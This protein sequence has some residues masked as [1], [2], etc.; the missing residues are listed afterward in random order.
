MARP[1]IADKRL[2]VVH[3]LRTALG[4]VHAGTRSAWVLLVLAPVLLSLGLTLHA[5]PQ[6]NAQSMSREPIAHWPLDN[7]ANDAG[8]NYHGTLQPSGNGAPVFVQHSAGEGV[9]SHALRLDG[10]NDFVALGAHASN[11]PQ[12][13]S[14]RSITGWFSV[15]SSAIARSTF[16]AYGTRANGQLF[17][18]SADRTQATVGVTGHQ[19]GIT[20]LNLD[21]GW[22]HIA[23]IYPGN[24][25]SDAIKIY[26]DGVLQTSGTLAGTPRAINTGSSI[27]Q[28]GRNA[29]GDSYY[30]GD[31]DDVRVY[32]VELS[33]AEVMDLYSPSPLQAS[34]ELV[35]TDL[36]GA[37]ITLTLVGDEFAAT[38][39]NSHVTVSGLSGVSVTSVVRDSDTQLSVTLAHDGSDISMHTPLTFTVAAA[40]LVSGEDPVSA[41]LLVNAVFE[42]VTYTVSSPD[43]SLT[44]TVTAEGGNLSYVVS[45]DGDEL[46]AESAL[47]IRDGSD[48]L[49]VGS[50]AA[51]HDS[52]WEPTW[53]LYE[54]I[55]DHH[56]SLTLN[57]DVGGIEFDLVF[58]VFND[59]LGF[60]FAAD[61]QPA[62]TGTTL[63]FNVRY[64]LDAS[65]EA[66]W[67]NG[68]HSPEGPHA[69]GSL[70]GSPAIGTPVVIDAGTHGFMAL[71]ESDLYS[72]DAFASI[73]FARVSGESAIESESRSGAIPAGDFITPW[74]VVLVGDTPGDLLES[75]VAVNLAAPLAL[76]DTTW[77]EPGKAFFNFRTL[78]YETDDGT[79]TYENN[80]ASVQRLIDHAV[81]LGFEYVNTDGKWF[82]QIDNG[83]IVS[84][85]PGFDV[86]TI[87]AY[88]EANEIYTTIY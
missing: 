66:W 73:P 61:E 1:Y 71:L 3:V 80:T 14:A 65:Y 32:G 28:I 22:H 11:F 30:Q 27:A 40:A 39:S 26:V 59:G 36:N 29:A 56:N 83:V 4:K 13:K 8:G 15:G 87:L 47:S 69:L 9:G 2:A 72:A 21:A 86:S 58:R 6:V 38:V 43:G 24:G 35:E 70:P 62:L 41:E 34:G 19:W 37:T 46:I 53:G 79:F 81:D 33:A 63:D 7:D 75:T 10:S 85:L 20:G 54:T 68:E 74:R 12:G 5:P 16:F 18:I 55:R 51:S 17:A 67:A 52:T 50:Q 49:V 64:N 44:A 77:I 88:A 25:R 31:I 57:L 84:Q 82:D 23:A 42:A 45:R 48:H 60:R 76:D 78:G